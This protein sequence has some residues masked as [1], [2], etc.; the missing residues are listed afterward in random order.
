MHKPYNFIYQIVCVFLLDIAS[1]ITTHRR[2]D[3]ACESDIVH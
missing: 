3:V 2:V 1:W